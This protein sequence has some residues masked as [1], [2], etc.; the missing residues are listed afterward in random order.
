MITLN[1]WLKF[2]GFFYNNRSFKEL[3]IGERQEKFLYKPSKK[4]LK[5]YLGDLEIL[6]A[7]YEYYLDIGDKWMHET[8]L[9]P[10]YLNISRKSKVSFMEKNSDAEF[11]Q[12]I[13]NKDYFLII[14]HLCKQTHVPIGF[15]QYE[16]MDNIIRLCN[17]FILP[18][19]QGI[20]YGKKSYNE[21]INI[22][23]NK[24]DKINV[25]CP[26][27]WALEFW[28]CV[29]NKISVNEHEDYYCINGAEEFDGGITY[30]IS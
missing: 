16:E 3:L 28:A 8:Q 9:C 5:T 21:F 29:T 4:I 10:E 19:W 1:N 25:H 22:F 26:R 6:E 30:N 14:V 20:G 15:I 2:K 24:F 7:A 18:S 27:E 23:K 11:W 17:I 12:K 13:N